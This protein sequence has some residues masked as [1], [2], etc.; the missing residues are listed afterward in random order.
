MACDRQDM[1]GGDSSAF[2]LGMTGEVAGLGMTTGRDSSAFGLG[3]T[4]E[5]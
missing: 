4:R 3:M 1:D 2:G 5:P